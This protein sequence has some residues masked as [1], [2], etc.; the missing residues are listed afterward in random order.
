VTHHGTAARETRE[1][2]ESCLQIIPETKHA[3]IRK[4]IRTGDSAQIDATLHEL[5][6]YKLLQQLHF[7]LEYAPRITGLEEERTPD[8]SVQIGGQQFIV[9]VFVRHTPLRTIKRY[10]HGYS[11]TDRGDTAKE[12]GERVSEKCQKYEIVD[13]PLLLV[14]FLGDSVLETTDVQVALYGASIGDGN[15]DDQFPQRITTLRPSGGVL[16]PE[17][18]TDFPRHPNLSAVVACRWFD[19]SNRGNPGKRLHCLVLHH[20]QPTVLVHPGAFHPLPELV[21]RETP[22]GVWKPHLT[23]PSNH[24]VRFGAGNIFEFRE[25]KADLPW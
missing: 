18:G 4:K 6:A 21:W 5:V 15:L 9:D 22:S 12:F 2:L 16:L 1:F 11:V 13:L 17:Y 25:Y 10:T 19:T 8:L 23:A 3:G 7:E 20:W 14:I 24:V